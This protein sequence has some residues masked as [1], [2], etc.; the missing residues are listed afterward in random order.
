MAKLVLLAL[1]LAACTI[2]VG[3]DLG[4]PG[5]GDLRNRE[6]TLD[7][8]GAQVAVTGCISGIVGPCQVE[9][10]D[11]M[12]VTADGMTYGVPPATIPP[13][14]TVIGDTG[15]V[16]FRGTV[17]APAD[18]TVEVVLAGETGRI[19][20]PPAFSITPPPGPVSR[21]AGSLVIAF[22]PVAGARASADETITCG[23]DQVEL[24]GLA[25]TTPGQLELMLDDGLLAGTC[26][27]AVAIHQT[28]AVPSS[29]GLSGWAVR[30]A[31][32]T[33]TSVP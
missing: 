19:D 13:D 7:D 15:E 28:L 18:P 11:T 22:E 14:P 24:D 1:A 12:T 17:P 26:S 31:A 6:V 30:T 21:G 32:I 10:G 4:D 29:Q 5:A 2:D 20:L 27:H 8:D 9:G 3:P 25:V 33:F 23:S 16:E